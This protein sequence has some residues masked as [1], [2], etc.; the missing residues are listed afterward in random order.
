[1]I[2]RGYL[3]SSADEADGAVAIVESENCQWISV[4]SDL[5]SFEDPAHFTQTGAPLSGELQT[6]VLGISCFDSDYLYLNLLNVAENTDAW[7]G[8]GS[9]AGLGIKRRSGL[10]HWKKLVWDYPAFSTGAKKNYILA[11][12]F[13]AVAEQCLGLPEIQSA[14]AYEYLED[15]GL[16]KI[17]QY[18][19]FKLSDQMQN[20]EPT[21]LVTHM[22]SLMPCC[23]GKYSAVSA[24]NVGEGARGL[25]VYF[26]GPYVEK[27]EITF[28]DVHFF[29][30]KKNLNNTTPIELTKVQLQNGEWAY[31]YHDPGFRIPPKVDDRLPVSKRMR[32]QMDNAIVV[33]F[34]PQGDSR[35]V[36]DITVVLAPDKYPQNNAA[37]N[38]WK[39][40]GS[41]KAFADQHNKT[42]GRWHDW[43]L[44]SG[45]TP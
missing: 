5:L 29:N 16:D 35:K 32:A 9:A 17:A 42:W 18:H 39:P 28:T 1:M 12:D 45:E 41:K 15:Y 31:H 30:P 25:S 4:Y 19:Y 7:I 37:W 40:F 3:A 38:V 27:E 13:L 6:D 33:R 10:A 11:E 2:D 14:A 43:D 20:K 23:I 34:V 36:L 22:Y 44:D 21:K 26:V 24:V 8:I